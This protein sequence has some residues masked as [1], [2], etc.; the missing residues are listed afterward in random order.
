VLGYIARLDSAQRQELLSWKSML[1]YP[2]GT[3]SF[4]S[5]CYQN[6]RG[7]GSPKVGDSRYEPWISALCLAESSQVILDFSALIR[8]QG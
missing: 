6:P 2:L 5:R 4:Q 3:A 8:I 7:Y 1:R